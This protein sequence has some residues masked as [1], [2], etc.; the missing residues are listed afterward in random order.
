MYDHFDTPVKRG[1][2]PRTLG[3]PASPVTRSPDESMYVPFAW[4]PNPFAHSGSPSMSRKLVN[5]TSA[6]WKRVEPVFWGR[7]N[8][9]GP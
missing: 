5:A 4:M 2:V 3:E 8:R 1:R 9:T 7:S 6:P